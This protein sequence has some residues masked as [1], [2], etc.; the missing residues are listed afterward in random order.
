MSKTG[1]P[2]FTLDGLDGK[3]YVQLI[4]NINTYMHDHYL[5]KSQIAERMETAPSQLGRYLRLEML[6]QKLAGTLPEEED[7]TVML[8]VIYL[9]KICNAMQVTLPELMV[10]HMTVAATP[11]DIQEQIHHLQ[12][13]MNN[14]ENEIDYLKSKMSRKED[15]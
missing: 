7:K 9:L 12:D 2:R 15:I 5:S 6:E 14:F 10:Y 8:S 3:Q 1:R 13:K 4:K 11:K